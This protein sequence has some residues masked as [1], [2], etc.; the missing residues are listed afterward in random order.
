MKESI[1]EGNQSTFS[2]LWARVLSLTTGSLWM[3]RMRH[4]HDNTYE[5]LRYQDLKCK[6]CLSESVERLD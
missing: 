5:M 2:A 4:G 6:N 3:P 1:L